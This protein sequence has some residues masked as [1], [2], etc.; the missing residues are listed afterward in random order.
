MILR[1]LSDC[2]CVG[3]G[4]PTRIL[5]GT[6]G[7]QYAYVMTFAMLHSLGNKNNWWR[8]SKRPPRCYWTHES[9]VRCMHIPTKPVYTNIFPYSFD[10]NLVVQKS[11]SD[12]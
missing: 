11:R 4:R 7:C 8:M 3:M 1:D 5:S 12:E 10:S 2:M 9:V 6:G